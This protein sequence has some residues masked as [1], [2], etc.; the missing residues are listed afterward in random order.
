MDTSLQNRRFMFERVRALWSEKR[1]SWCAMDFEAYEWEHMT[2]TEFG[3]S[4]VT[5]VN[6]EPEEKNGHLIVKENRHLINTR[7]VQGNRDV[8]LFRFLCAWILIGM[9]MDG[10]LILILYFVWQNY[11]FGES[12]TIPKKAFAKRINDMIDTLA[13][14]GP[15][16][17]IFHDHGQDVKSVIFTYLFPPPELS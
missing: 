7:W 11:S 1:G 12:E 4:Y 5:F 8:S 6:G 16:F 14:N 13:K 10:I 17:L 15:L 2:V 9:V 3:W